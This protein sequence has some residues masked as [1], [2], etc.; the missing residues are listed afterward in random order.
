[1]RPDEDFKG[2][3][4]AGTGEGLAHA[5][6][7]DFLAELSSLFP[8]A[9]VDGT[10]WERLLALARQLPIYVTDNRFGFE[11]DLC[12][13]EPTADFC[14]VPSPGSRLAGFYVRQGELAPP[15][16]AEAALGAFLAEQASDRQELLAGG[17]RGGVILEYDLAGISSDQLAPP[18]IF[19]VP[20]EGHDS[21]HE[22]LFGD[23][24]RLSGALHAV[25]G[26]PPDEGILRQMQRIFRL[27]QPIAAISQ[28][29]ILPGR[30]QRAIRLII[31]TE[32]DKGAI[33]LLAR[34]GWPGSL[35]DVAAVC[36]SLAGLTRQAVSLSV[37]VTAQGIS[38]R[39]GLEF[40]RPV[41]WH[42]LDR[43]GWGALVDQ[44][45]ERGWCLPE[46]ARGLKAWPRVEQVFD[47]AQV[48]RVQQ[49]INHV[50]VVVNRAAIVAKAYA[51]TIVLQST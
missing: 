42:D 38:P 2:N 40:H 44:L 19:I 20:R 51:G 36:D 4:G 30:P 16:S 34:L 45:E 14:V 3:C 8:S 22:E 13:P 27:I 25:A 28:A 47:E 41:E 31:G 37:D 33:E 49:S 1:M 6:F 12:D 5:T 10:G 48:Y 23:P 35:A 21:S 43:T 9:L 11:F 50:K 18:G 26:R 39:L 17:E 15:E 7:G 32:P 46:K 29:G 24:E